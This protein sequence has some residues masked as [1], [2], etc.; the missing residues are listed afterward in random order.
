MVEIVHVF[1]NIVLVNT[2][3]KIKYVNIVLVLVNIYI[4][5]RNG[6]LL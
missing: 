3:N 2:V 4:D 6:S 5:N 1:V